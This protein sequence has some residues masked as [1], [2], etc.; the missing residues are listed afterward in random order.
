MSEDYHQFT[1]G[2]FSE[3]SLRARPRKTER[4][5]AGKD[6]PCVQVVKNHC[7]TNTVAEISEASSIIPVPEEDSIEHDVCKS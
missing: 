7:E 5:E 6:N 1:R 3:F 4:Y 2:T